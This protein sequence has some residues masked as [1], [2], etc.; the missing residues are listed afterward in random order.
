MLFPEVRGYKWMLRMQREND[1][2]GLPGRFA[3][4][5]LQKSAALGGVIFDIPRIKERALD[6]SRVIGTQGIPQG[7][8]VAGID[9]A[10]RGRQAAHLWS[11]T[12]TT[13]YMVDLEVQKAGGFIGAHDLMERWHHAYGLLDWVYEDNAGQ[14]EFFNDPRFWKLTEKLGLN[15]MRHTTG[16]NKHDPEIGITQ[17]APWYHDG[18]INLPYG[19]GESR[20]KV[21]ALLRELE[22]WT[23]GSKAKPGKSDMK[24]AQWFP[25]PRMLS[26]RSAQGPGLTVE[27]ESSGYGVSYPGIGSFSD[28]NEAPWR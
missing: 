2:L 6:R 11:Y 5:Y 3:L 8:L 1:N 19:N 16:K 9:P 23:D 27:I 4:R 24:M 18:I 13:V 21:N 26:R 17:M 7:W 14:I 15:V 28:M 10:A 20:N 25:F 22:L 12:D